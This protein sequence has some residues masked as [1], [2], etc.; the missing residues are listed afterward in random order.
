MIFM[1][2][3]ALHYKPRKISSIKENDLRICIIGK[4]VETKENS[5]FISDGSGELEVFSE[6]PVE[7]NSI[8]RVFCS[9]EGDKFKADVIQNLKGFDLNLY[10]KIEELY[11]R[12]ESV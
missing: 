3:Q 5:F 11:K 6:K 9:R 8:V 2:F 12:V 4:V 7:K 10:S 1:P